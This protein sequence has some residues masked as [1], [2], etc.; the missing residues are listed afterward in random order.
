MRKHTV[1][2]LI[3][4]CLAFICGTV[5]AAKSCRPSI[6]VM[7]LSELK[8]LRFRRNYSPGMFP[9]Q[10]RESCIRLKID[11]KSESASR[12]A[13][14]LEFGH[15]GTKY[16]QETLKMNQDFHPPKSLAELERE[17]GNIHEG[18]G[19]KRDMADARVLS[20]KPAGALSDDAGSSSDEELGSGSG[21]ET[22]S[23]STIS[24]TSN[25][26]TNGKV[27]NREFTDSVFYNP[28]NVDYLYLLP[29]PFQIAVS[30]ERGATLCLLQTKVDWW[31]E[32]KRMSQQSQSQFLLKYFDTM[33][34]DYDVLPEA[35]EIEDRFPF[36]IQEVRV[37]IKCTARLKGI[38]S[39]RRIKDTLEGLTAAN[40]KQEA[41]YMLDIAKAKAPLQQQ[42]S[43]ALKS[44][45]DP[46]VYATRMPACRNLIKTPD[47]W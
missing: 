36:T 18:E 11:F 13:A 20:R 47:Y 9:K 10:I 41:E 46:L 40:M 44:I 30:D 32:R 39:D 2:F 35:N 31:E 27:E 42:Q 37:M 38:E 17:K 24:L 8:Q 43:S 6:T 34:L 33:M 3:C 29:E 5:L 23:S 19:K 7:E 16:K 26:V 1:S 22:S 15:P 28:P 14:K 21:D 25:T 4:Y 45:W 12:S